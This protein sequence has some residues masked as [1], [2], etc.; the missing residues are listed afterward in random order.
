MKT[1]YEWVY[2]STLQ[3][4]HRLFRDAVRDRLAIC[5][6]SGNTPSQTEDGV[7]WLDFDRI[8]RVGMHKGE[9]LLSV[10]VKGP[11]TSVGAFVMVDILDAPAL[12]DCGMLF[13]SDD[14]R[15]E[16]QAWH[17]RIGKLRDIY[18]LIQ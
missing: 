9:P 1:Q 14:C 7:L 6:Q 18:Q 17:E 10:P 4:G 16:L 12:A 3:S 11:R 8:I 2:L 15:T 13:G 5:D